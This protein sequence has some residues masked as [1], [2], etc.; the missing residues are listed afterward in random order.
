MK[1][2]KNNFD[3]RLCNVFYCHKCSFMIGNE[4]KWLRITNTVKSEC[5]GVKS[6]SIS[7]IFTL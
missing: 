3:I 7:D 2:C 1:I 6:N 4:C 5:G